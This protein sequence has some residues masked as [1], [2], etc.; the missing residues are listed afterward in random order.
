MV[1]GGGSGGMEYALAAHEAGHAV[2]L[3]ERTNELG[4]V[5]A[6]AGN[7]KTLPNM[8]Q[9]AYQSDWHR[10]MIE[11]M[12]VAVRYGQ[13]V[14]AET[15][16]AE[17]PDIV[18]VATGARLV[19]PEIS[20]LNAALKSGLALT[21]DDVLRGDA[22]LKDGAVV[23]WGA[24]QGIE[25][26]LDLAQQGR[27]VRLLDPAPVFAPMHYI[28]SR[29]KYVAMWM[30]KVDL[31]VEENVLLEEIGAYRYRRPQRRQR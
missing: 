30:K 4:G 7:Y 3:W 11:K 13:D 23:V 15:V 1:V 6:W 9:V 8:E 21:L 2:T 24:S 19:M 18:V 31:A 17:R 16:L 29:F 28:G 25:L 26:A 12:G 27:N 14:S 10:L 5:M 22:N 20:G